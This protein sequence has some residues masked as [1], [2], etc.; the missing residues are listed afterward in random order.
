MQ[1]DVSWH[2]LEH[3]HIEKSSDWF[4]ALGIV[5]GSAALASIL[6]GNFLFALLIVIGAS[7][8][9]LLANKVPVEIEVALT[10][11]GILIGPE[12]YPYE[13]LAGFWVAEDSAEHEQPVLLLDSRKWLL[14]HIVVPL[15]DVPIDTVRTYL[16]QYLPQTELKEPFGHLIF[17]L[18]GY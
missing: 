6:F 10:P 15:T 17:E 8:L 7:T 5:A 9:G 3:T 14:P 4:W 2:T 12:F 11:K 16:D 13:M 1:K 18:F